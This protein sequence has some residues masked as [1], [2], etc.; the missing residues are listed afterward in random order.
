MLFKL[1]PVM[2]IALAGTMPLIA[3]VALAQTIQ[4]GPGQPY[5]TIQAGIDAAVNGDTV[6]V[7]PGTYHE[8]INF[9]G[10]AITVTSSVGAATTIIDGGGTPGLAVVA[11]QSSENRS[12]V[13]SGFTIRNGG[14]NTFNSPA[15]GGIYVFEASPTILNNIITAN[16]CNG[17]DVTDGAALIQ[18]NTISATTLEAGAYCWD[19]VALALEGNQSNTA[20]PNSVIGN[21]IENNTAQYADSGAAIFIWVSNGNIIVGNIIRNNVSSQGAVQM[22]N[23]ESIIFSQNLVY[24]NSIS[25]TI[26]GY[27]GAGGLY[28]AIPDGAPPFYGV[29]VNN[30]FANNTVAP[31]FN[32]PASQVL[33]DG[34]VSQF[35]FVNNILYGTG[36]SPLLV[37]NGLYAYLS[38]G[39]ML[40]ENNDVFNPSGPAYDPSCANGAGVAGNIAVDPLF[41]NLAS[42]DFHLQSSSPVI[43]AGNNQALAM[44]MPYG[45]DLT[46]DLDGNHRIQNGTGKGCVIDM[47]TY[48]YPGTPC[49]VSE[50]LTSSLNP[51]MAG[52]SVTFTAQL[53]SSN[54]TPT[55]SI[56]FLDGPILLSTQPV[57]GSGS[58]SFTTNALTVGSH[59]I[60]ANY[61]PT[62][63]FGSSSA[64]LIEVITGDATGTTLTCL[65]NPIYI[66]GT[67]QFAAAVT[68]A[69]GTPTGSVAFADNGSALGTQGLVNGATSLMYIGAAAGTHTIVATYEPTGSFA[70]SSATCSEVVDA[71][72]TVSTLTVAPSPGTYGTPVT[73]SATVVP[74]TP[75][76]PSIPTGTV[77][78]YSGATQIGTSTLAGGVATLTDGSLTGGSYN[79]T[80]IYG[81]SSIYAAS[82]CNSVPLVVNAA[83]TTLALTSSRNPV[84]Y[85]GTVSFTFRLTE[86]GQSAGAGNTIQLSFNGQTIA[87]TTDATGSASYGDILGNLQPGSYAVNAVFAGTNDLQ[88]SSASLTEVVTAAPTSIT[89]T[90]TPNPGDVNQAVSLTATVSQPQ[91]S[92]AT[93]IG[94]GSVSFYDGS[95]LL[96]SA[97]VAANSPILTGSV[98]ANLAATFA[99]VGIHNITAIYSGDPDYLTSTSAAF[100]ETIVAGDFSISV[101]PGSAT[102]YTGQQAAIAVSVASINGFNQ[103]L[104]FA[105]SGLPANAACIFNP[106]TLPNG[107][108]SVSLVIQTAAPHQAENATVSAAATTLG[109]FVLFFL[110][111]WRR[112]RRLLV[113]LS[114]VLL[115]V[116]IAAGISGCGSVDPV[117]G[118]TPPGSYQIAVTAT[119]TGNATPLQHAAVVDLTVQSLF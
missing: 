116:G 49:G 27:D 15:G 35:S 79:L 26:V 51:A 9:N 52:Q 3:A 45:V 99:I 19:G 113:G 117:A 97:P 53:S 39:P 48:E 10:K 91:P 66:S 68:S 14:P 40:V 21:T 114:A 41:N 50:T 80:C 109:A 34:D 56:Q 73:L 59:T 87:L 28:L 6:L 5:T 69:D 90:G 75:P 33:I 63:M 64:S 93:L 42:D 31:V 37:C 94:S 11:F 4:V 30:T 58:A 72:P 100:D 77:T 83:P 62:G 106:T 44:L 20:M 103:P 57:S 81:G 61:Q 32:E 107:Q 82:N 65:P 112:R 96:G 60:V 101:I 102:L 71:L 88:A 29:M 46:S 92:S 119:T 36:S 110:P 25:G 16:G 43:D 55:G 104:A 17:I 89:L 118:G 84:A 74:A 22:F 108:G 54:G 38:P 24:G 70:A 115:A 98:T 2:R 111:G 23:S 13:L 7:A 95:T 76:G 12:S 47:G 78:F 18:G 1:L 85:G 8:N 86:N 105:C 67:A